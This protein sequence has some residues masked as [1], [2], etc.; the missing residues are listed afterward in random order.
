MVSKDCVD[1]AR[2]LTAPLRHFASP[3][4]S[5]NASTRRLYSLDTVPAMM[6][7]LLGGPGLW[8]SVSAPQRGDLRTS[9]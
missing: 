8:P 1:N 3:A 2:T 9:Q 4:A 7:L 6:N 5:A